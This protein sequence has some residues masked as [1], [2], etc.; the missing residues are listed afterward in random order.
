[1]LDLGSGGS[2]LLSQDTKSTGHVWTGFGSDVLW[3]KQVA[4]TTELWIDDAA[5]P[6]KRYIS[7]T[8]F[9]PDG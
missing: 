1:M 6:G 4:G 2:H 8:S 3:Q 9:L 5:A 7:S